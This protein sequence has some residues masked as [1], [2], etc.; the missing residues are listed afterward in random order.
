MSSGSFSLGDRVRDRVAALIARL[1]VTVAVGSGASS[2]SVP[3]LVQVLSGVERSPAF[4]TGEIVD[5]LAPAYLLTLAGDAQ[6]IAVGDPVTLPADYPTP[7]ALTVRKIERVLL[8]ATCVK[9]LLF[10]A[11]T[12]SG[13]SSPTSGG[14]TAGYE[15]VPQW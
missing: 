13:G 11:A 9:T 6:P 15:G 5:W 4:R 14:A 7:G 12:N 10:C 8:G 2:R 3:A 1:G